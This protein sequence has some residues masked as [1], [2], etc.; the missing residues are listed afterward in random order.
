VQSIQEALLDVETQLNQLASYNS[1]YHQAEEQDAL[2]LSVNGCIN[3]RANHNNLAIIP[4]AFEKC[5]TTFFTYSQTNASDGIWA[6]IPLAGD[7]ADDQAFN[8][9][10]NFHNQSYTPCS[11]GCPTPFAVLINFLAQYPSINLAQSPL[12]TAIPLANP[13]EW[14]LGAR[15]YLEMSHEFPQYAFNRGAT[16]LDQL[17]TIG[18]NV[19]QAAEN[20]NSNRP[21]GGPL[22]SNQLLL[23]GP[24]GLTNKY[25][26]AGANLNVAMQ[27]DLNGY[28]SDP[29]NGIVRNNISL[30]L[31]AGGVNQHTAWRPALGTIN[32]CSGNSIGP[33]PDGVLANVPDLYAFSQGYL[34]SG[35]LSMC[36]SLGQQW[37]NLGP[38]Q[39]GSQSIISNS[40]QVLPGTEDPDFPGDYDICSLIWRQGTLTGSINVSFNGTQVLSANISKTVIAAVAGTWKFPIDPMC[41]APG[42]P[43][44]QEY[45]PE[46][47]LRANWTAGVNFQALFNSSSQVVK[48]AQPQ[49]LASVV[50]QL[51]SLASQHQKN[52]YSLIAKD[53]GNG[54][55]AVQASSSTLD[56]ARLLLQ[57]FV[58]L[59]LP[60]SLAYNDSLHAALYG[61]NGLLDSAVVQSDFNGFGGA[62][63]SDTTDNKVNDE[64]AD[65]NARLS[66]LVATLNTV[67][68]EVNQNQVPEDLSQVDITLEDLRAFESM[69]N[70]AVSLNNVGLLSPCDYHLSSN[71][72]NIDSKGGTATLSVQVEAG[73]N[74]QATTGIP[75]LSITSGGRGSGAGSSTV[76]AQANKS[77]SARQATVVIGDQVFRVVQDAVF[78]PPK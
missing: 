59:G 38:W 41:K 35:Q 17:I 18:S 34:N 13:D 50:S 11:N 39:N 78:S 8:T 76:K 64:I 73:C 29:K 16:Y 7:Y 33:A 58:N 2:M 57:A 15:A 1:Y 24:S 5:Q 21:A 36:I 25:S 30:D 65:L 37:E 4:Q 43:L 72:V 52:I 55:S 28:V 23:A 62:N 49:I 70:A 48:E 67:L 51:D 68:G 31:F 63:I 45:S 42:G 9:I 66:S 60:N 75:W 12:S 56:G 54:G 71:G 19:E 47:V 10:S 46:D 3:Y 6:P 61:S 26:T 74:W 20:I 22:T 44:H 77:G 53:I 14:V 40:G 69:Q 27:N 32:I